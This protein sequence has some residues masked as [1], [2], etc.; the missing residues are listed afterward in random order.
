MQKED[1]GDKEE[2]CTGGWKRVSEKRPVAD[3][4]ETAHHLCAIGGGSTKVVCG[5]EGVT[6]DYGPRKGSA[7]NRKRE[8]GECRER[9]GIRKEKTRI[10]RP[11][12]IK[13]GKKKKANQGVQ[14]T[15]GD[16]QQTIRRKKRFKWKQRGDRKKKSPMTRWKKM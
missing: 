2:R 4:P 11:I 9:G 10:Q 14:Q 5:T 6:R 16:A 1:K 13:S 15:C 8:R 3:G 7:L 12:Q